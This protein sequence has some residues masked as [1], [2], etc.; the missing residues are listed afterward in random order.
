MISP[1]VQAYREMAALNKISQELTK[2]QIGIVSYE[3]ERDVTHITEIIHDVLSPLAT[4]ITIA[5][6]FSE[7]RGIDPKDG[8]FEHV[9]K[10]RPD[11]DLKEE[12]IAEVGGKY[13]WFQQELRLSSLDLGNQRIDR[14]G[15]GTFVFLTDKEPQTLGY[16]TLGTN[17]AYRRAVSDLLTSALL[18]FIRGHLN[19]VTDN[20]GVRLSGLKGK[21]VDEWLSEIQ[22]TAQEA[23]LLW[24]V[25]SYPQSD[26]LLGSDERVAFVEKLENPTKK[27][28]WEQKEPGLCIYSLDQSES[29][30]HHIIRRVLKETQATIWLGVARPGF[31][32]ELNSPSP[33]KFFI[34]HFSA[35][36]DS[37]L[38]RIL[39]NEEQKRRMAEVQGLVTSTFTKGHILHQLV[40]LARG[41][42]SASEALRIGLEQGTLRG[43]DRHKALISSFRGTSDQIEDL[44]KLF[45]DVFKRD[46]RQPCSLREVVEHALG[47]VED[48]LM[49][50]K[51]RIENKIPPAAMVD[52]PFH[53][54]ANAFSIVIDNAKD[55]I[56][57]RRETNGLIQIEARETED[58]FA[59]DIIDNGPGVQSDLVKKLFNQVNKSRK[60]NGHGLGLYFSASLLRAYGADIVLTR[61]G[62]EPNTTFSIYF[63]KA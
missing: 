17:S 2:L 43:N 23:G 41:L 24:A 59:C 9:S 39:F 27:D 56:R 52:V 42:T 6:G 14:Q 44:L 21:R 32:S 62:P 19:Q 46:E 54:A 10:E 5:M 18:D 47:S 51:I 33:W 53:A 58:K 15:L 35:L 11:T 7:Y 48:S 1:A 25:A 20:L 45:A 22:R 8:Y 16:P 26:H 29:G 34:D 37:A 50:Y 38:L 31:G 61:P 60:P 13:H 30:T 28:E 3:M 12:H 57:D 49:Q 63:P 55:A 4:G 36:A 40:N